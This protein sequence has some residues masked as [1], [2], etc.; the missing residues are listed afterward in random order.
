[1]TRVCG[2]LYSGEIGGRHVEGIHVLRQA[3]KYN[4]CLVQTHHPHSYISPHQR[5]AMPELQLP[6]PLL[7]IVQEK[8]NLSV[9]AITSVPSGCPT[10]RFPGGSS[11]RMSL[12]AHNIAYPCPHNPEPLPKPPLEKQWEKALASSSPEKQA[13]VTEPCKPRGLAASW[14]KKTD[15]APVVLLSTLCSINASSLSV[16]IE[17][18]IKCNLPS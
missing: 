17:Q 1:M 6:P 10:V 9:T 13:R 14:T 7:G 8:E 11:A 2:W 12:S 5:P 16:V 3:H 18:Q 4:F 15:H